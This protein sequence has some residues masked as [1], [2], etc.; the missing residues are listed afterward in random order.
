[1]NNFLILKDSGASYEERLSCASIQHPLLSARNKPDDEDGAV[2][3]EYLGDFVCHTY[4]QHKKLPNPSFQLA[5]TIL[6]ESVPIVLLGDEMETESK[7]NYFHAKNIDLQNNSW[8]TDCWYQL[9]R[10]QTLYSFETTFDLPNT[11]QTVKPHKSVVELI[12]DVRDQLD[13]PFVFNLAKRLDFLVEASQEEY[14]DQ[15][16]ISPQSLQDFV[17]FLLEPNNLSCPEVV[18]TPNGNIRSQWKKSRNQH[19]A[20][21]YLGNRN[22]RFVVFAPDQNDLDKI[23][24]VSGQTSLDSLIDNVKPYGVL[25]WSTLEIELAA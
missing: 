20:V 11:S 2:V 24:R 9:L 14:P 23:T 10:P 21:E 8:S 1:M 25:S 18:L 5:E 4:N 22:V 16:P 17:N 7:E 6:S 15:E 19:F 3:K 12:G 13:V